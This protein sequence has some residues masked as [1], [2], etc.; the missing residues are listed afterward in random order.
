[1]ELKRDVTARQFRRLRLRALLQLRVLRRRRLVVVASEQ[2]AERAALPVVLVALVGR[3][4]RR[5]PVVRPRQRAPVVQGPVQ[6]VR[7]QV[8]AAQPLVQA[9]AASELT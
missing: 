1:V 2:W 6:V 5:A 3:R 9:A 4:Q 7:V 8:R